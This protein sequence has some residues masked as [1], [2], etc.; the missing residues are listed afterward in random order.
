MTYIPRHIAIG[1]LLLPL[2]IGCTPRTCPPP[3]LTVFAGAGTAPAMNAI[4]DAF[5]AQTGIHI[6]Y[7]YAN[8]AQLA[9]QLE[10]GTPADV[11]LSANRKWM[12]YAIG[13][14]CINTATCTDLLTTDLVIIAPKN[15]PL[16]VDFTKPRQNQT[17]N[18]PF[19]IGDPGFS[20]AGIYAE[21]SFRVLG[22]WDTLKPHL[23]PADTINKVLHYVELNEADAGA[24][25]RSVAALS[26]QI[27]IMG[28]LPAETHKPIRFPV[29]QCA[30]ASSEAGRFIQFL[31]SSEASAIFAAFGWQTIQKGTSK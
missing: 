8:A 23:M 11:F 22:W 17:F 19:A 30:D 12:Q 4:A 15:H 7:N 31:K 2:L 5:T 20:P 3:S 16:S 9:K 13:K 29:A 6:A 10:A 21:Q 1:I 24:V 26:K 27:E 25:F 14:G 28:T 18:G